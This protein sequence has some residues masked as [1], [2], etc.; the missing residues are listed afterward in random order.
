MEAAQVLNV[1]EQTLDDLIKNAYHLQ[2]NHLDEREYRHFMDKQDMLL[3][4]ILNLQSQWN[5]IETNKTL[6]KNPK[7]YQHLSYKTQ[8]LSTINQNRLRSLSSK[9]VK[10]GKAQK[11]YLKKRSHQMFFDLP[12]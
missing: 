6:Q 5:Q 9:M 4:K 12:Q 10:K 3:D 8:Q 11:V 1:L 7:K 2:E